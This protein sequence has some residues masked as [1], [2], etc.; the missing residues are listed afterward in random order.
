MSDNTSTQYASLPQTVDGITIA[1][2]SGAVA[3]GDSFLIRPTRNAAAD[4]VLAVTDPA[5][6]AAAAPIRTSAS[7]NNS[8]S[9]I[10]SAGT[11][12]TPPPPNANLQ[13]LVTITFTSPTQFK[14]VGLGTLNPSGLAYTAGA[15]VSYNGWTVKITGTPATGDVFTISTNDGGVADGRNALRLAGLQAQNTLAGASATYQSAYSELA[16][17]IGSK[18]Q[19]M[20]VTAQAQATIA[21]QA[22]AAQQSFSGVNL[23]EEAANLLRYQQAYQ[24]AGKMMQIAS[25]LFQTL[26]NLGQ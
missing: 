10:I 20:D 24:A 23:D 8:G 21:S 7:G 11:V 1:V 13:N 18:T 22:T 15:D 9:A 6:I 4:I 5:Q 17:L 14:V 25:T 26:L 16:S 2:G 12:D 3:N 19:E